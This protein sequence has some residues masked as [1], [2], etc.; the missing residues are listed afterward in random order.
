M[1]L[2]SIG[3]PHL[4]FGPSFRDEVRYSFGF[5]LKICGQLR[6]MARIVL[7]ARG[8]LDKRQLQSYIS[9]CKRR[10]L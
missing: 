3:D 1:R 8:T 10:V 7:R 4:I 6:D 2:F 9:F 5:R